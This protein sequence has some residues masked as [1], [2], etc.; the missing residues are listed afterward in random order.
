[1]STE[2][3]SK[4]L[5]TVPFYDQFYATTIDL[6]LS[7]G[8]S[9]SR[10]LDTGC[11][12]GNLCARATGIFSG[13]EF[14]LSDPSEQMLAVAKDKLKTN[15]NVSYKLADTQSL[16]YPNDYF[17]VITAIQ[18]HHY[19]D[20]PG[21]VEAVANCFRMLKPGGIFV[22]FENIR[23]FSSEGNSIGL[24]RWQDYQISMGRTVD[25]AAAHMRRFD[26]EYFPISVFDHVDLLRDTGFKTV[27][28]LWASFMQAGF[29]AIK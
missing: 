14:A 11:G 2:F 29:Y 15:P 21:R 27:E 13:A 26:H 28:V 1:M 20:K 4:I 9:T 19:L 24:K 25:E 8:K 17:D 16:D 18:C 3:D 23:A 22:E 5:C 6:V 12:T 7:T 10:W